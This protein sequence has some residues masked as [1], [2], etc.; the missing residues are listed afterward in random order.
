MSW[1][2]LKEFI[3]QEKIEFVDLRFTDLPGKEH[4]VTIPASAVDEDLF[5]FG[6]GIDGSSLK[7]W[8]DINQS[9]LALVPCADSIPQLDPFYRHKTLL[10]R[11]KVIDPVSK[12]DYLYDPRQIATQAESYLRQS[13]IADKVLFGPEPEFFIFDD[14]QWDNQMG[15]VFYKIQSCEA[16]WKSS[17]SIEGGNIGH[18]PGIGGGYF[19]VPPVDSSQDIRSSISLCLQNMGIEVE[20]HHHEVAGA[21][22]C[23]VATKCNTL[24]QKADEMQLL[25]YVIQNVAHQY[26]KTATFM[27]KPMVGDNGSGMHCHQSLLLAGE[28]LFSGHEYAGLSKLALHYV[29]GILHHAKALNALT[30]PTINSYRRLVPGFEAPVY[31]GYGYRNRSAAVR[32]PFTTSH[33]ARRI[34]ARF[35]DCTANPYLAFSAMLMAGLDGIRRQIDPGQAY[36]NDLYHLNSD[37]KARIPR[38][39]SSLEDAMHALESDYEFL[40]EGGVFDQGFIHKWM[41]MLEEDVQLLRQAVHPMEFALYYSR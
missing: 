10:V 36:E 30:N 12:E 2:E 15:S 40:L 38:L 8:Q 37:E 20:T 17:E 22:Q 41:M 7:G 23:E 24:V 19:P 1:Q 11:A 39:S 14:V 9:D 34:E 21:N 16:H 4:H 31:L 28:N 33:K 35:P 13:G 25:K 18:R 3:E 26:G 5:S 27:P 32:I 6:K 29:G